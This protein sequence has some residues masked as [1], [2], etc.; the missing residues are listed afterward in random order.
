MIKAELEECHLKIQT[1][2][3]ENKLLK[4]RLT[5]LEPQEGTAMEEG[6]AGE[7]STAAEAVTEAEGE[8][9]QKP[10]AEEV[11]SA[12]NASAAGSQ[13]SPQ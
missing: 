7:P 3:D 2:E 4:E 5:Q 1:L 10:P 8:V 9:T 11:E 6:E 12:T 13:P